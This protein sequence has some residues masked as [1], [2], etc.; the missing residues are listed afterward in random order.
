[1]AVKQYPYTLQVL[2]QTP[3]YQDENGNWIP[4]TE[5]WVEH[6]KCRDEA[7]KGNKI[8]GEDGN[9]YDYSFLVQMPKGTAKLNSG[10]Q[11]KVLTKNLVQRATGTIIYSRKD[12]LH[13]RAWV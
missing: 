8:I 13:T 11:I 3:A 12:Q 4:G 2:V 9:E 7:G 10:N 6:S 1:M 5:Q